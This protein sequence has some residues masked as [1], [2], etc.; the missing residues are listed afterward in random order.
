MATEQELVGALTKADA[1][2]DHAGAQQI[3]DMI[4]AQRAGQVPAEAPPPTAPASSHDA[5]AAEGLRAGQEESPV[6]A[7]ISQAAMQ[8]TFGLQNYVNAGMRW[9]AQRAVGT[10][11]PDSFQDNLTYSRAKS[12]GEAGAHPIASTIGGT[13]GTIMGGAGIGTALKAA[14]GVTIAGRLI[15]AAAPGKS[16]VGN[17]AKSATING[18]ISGL[19]AVA[20]G[21]DLPTAGRQAAIGAVAGPVLSKTAQLALQKM[22]P[23]AQRAMMTLA[24]TLDEHPST[25]AAANQAFTHI[26]GDQ[27][28]LAMLTNLKS[29]GKLRALAAA[30]DEI[31]QV[32]AEAANRG[33]APLSQQLA[34]VAAARTNP[35][36]SAAML[37]LRDRNMNDVMNQPAPTTGNLGLKDAPVSLNTQR[38]V[39]ILM[40][41][42]VA[43][44]L[45]PDTRVANSA[46]GPGD[47]HQ[48][49]LNDTL[50]VGD[51][52]HIRLQL[53]NQQAVHDSPTAGTSRNPEVAKAYGAAANAIE[54]LAGSASGGHPAYAQAM[55]QYRQ[56]SRYSTGFQ[57][58]L[59]GKA[60]TEAT[61]PNVVRDLAHP[62]GIGAAGFEHGRLLRRGMDA[63][64]AIAPNT[65]RPQP[66]MGPADAVK[67]AH[68]VAAPSAI[69]AAGI[70]SHLKG[71]ALPPQAQRIV[72]D[73]LYSKD[74]ARVQQG[75]ANLDRARV[76]SDDLRKLAGVI[77]GVAAERITAHLD[78]RDH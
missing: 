55:H 47:L 5:A 38:K 49:I 46:F 31:G 67:V 50:T 21:D 20:Q 26:T 76:S 16:A 78:N 15:E 40:D 25:L 64:D 42:L 34:D 68:A 69:S 27:A 70:M 41:P 14:K 24:K 39:D 32:A 28:P 11:N 6:L 43:H 3:A 65:V 77:G 61:D 35:Q 75:I 52:D 9:A 22:T 10:K 72:A 73:M 30:N 44:A 17:V 12:E 74:P 51:L 18:G 48:A 1:A 37:D 58:A 45:R 23:V 29:Q 33:G 2:G 36:S 54:G 53:R 59:D 62:S 56:I 8:G 63:L 19:V 4:K 7:G 13:A 60:M 57:H 66:E 71:T